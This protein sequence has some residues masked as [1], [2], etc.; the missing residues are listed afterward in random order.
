MTNNRSQ[1]LGSNGLEDLLDK[2]DRHPRA[3]TAMLFMI[4]DR[5]G[6]GMTGR[7]AS[8]LRFHVPYWQA[9]QKAL[10]RGSN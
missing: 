3:T 9:K 8:S 1:N 2:F 5:A 6:L 7:D 10:G 4:T